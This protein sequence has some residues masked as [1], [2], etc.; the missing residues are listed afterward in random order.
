MKTNNPTLPDGYSAVPAGKLVN[1]VM[2]LEM[3]ERPSP[4]RAAKEPSSLSVS[5]W[6]SPDLDAYRALFRAIGEDWLWYSRLT[7]DDESLRAVLN[8]PLIEV[9]VLN[10]GEARV[11]LLELDFREDQQCELTWFGVVK[12]AIG[13]RAGRF[14][15]DFAI[16]TAWARPIRRFWVHT[17]HFDHPSAP[18]FYQRSGFR[19]YALFAEVMDDPRLTGVFPRTAA[20]HI[21]LLEPRN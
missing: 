13:K 12:E 7:M 20:L 11:G 3:F 8:D 5:R 6:T 10:D 18:A 19:L 2:C 4:K 16:D 15:M 21:P 1:A 9:Y 14:M 17:C